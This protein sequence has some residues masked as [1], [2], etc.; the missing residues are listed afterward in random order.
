MILFCC[1][2]DNTL[3]YSYK[4]ELKQKKRCVELYQ[5]REISFMTEDTYRLLKT[6]NNKVSIVPVTTRTVEQYQRIHLGIGTFDYALTCN[7]GVLFLNGKEDASWY[8]ETRKMIADSQEELVYGE[9]L[10]KKDKNRCFEVR[11][12]RGLF[13]FTKSEDPK[14]SAEYLKERINTQKADVFCNGIKVYIVPR[15]LNKGSATLRLKN[16]L[17]A[18]TAVAAGDS[19]FDIPMLNM[20]DF[21]VAPAELKGE[22][23]L[24]PKVF[25]T[26]KEKLFSE[27][28]LKKILDF[29]KEKVKTADK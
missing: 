23:G 26:E 25:Y 20:A 13:L 24:L 21:A 16:R 6:L 19:G 17:R 14:A 27:E 28:L 18:E 10:L 5:G 2:L 15:Q 3:I 22:K 4:H 8:E 12:I 11:N 7:G 9:E 1:D 29:T